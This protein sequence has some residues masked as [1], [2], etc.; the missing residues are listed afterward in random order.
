[1]PRPL[2]Y[3]LPGSPPA[4]A[5]MMLADIIGL[6]L[7]IKEIDF[8]KLE[9]KSEAFLKLNPMGTIPTL[10]DGDFV[11]SESHTIMKYLLEKYGGDKRE[12]LYPSDIRTR[13]LIDQCVFFETGVF[14]VRLKVVVLPAI[15]E[16]HPGPTPK[17]IADIEEAYGV[18][19]AY[20]GNK[21]YLVG[22]HLTLADL[23]LGATTTAME[24][25]HKVDPKRFPRVTNWVARLQN[26]PFFK[27]INAEGVASF[28]EILNACWAKNRK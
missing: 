25:I 21:P 4:R 22:N 28:S 2:L 1:M 20:L 3:F 24:V 27:S 18:V 14:F 23:S 6:E 10:Q 5:V 13:A 19:E 15:F 17:H 12:V 11:I 9:H 8:L 7:D 26:E 16:G